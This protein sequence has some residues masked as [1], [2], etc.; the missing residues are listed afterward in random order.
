MIAFPNKNLVHKMSNK[1]Q[2]YIYPN[3]TGLMHQDSTATS[4]TPTDIDSDDQI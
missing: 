4:V 3:P 2:Q 1:K